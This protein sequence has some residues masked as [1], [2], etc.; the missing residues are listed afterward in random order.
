MPRNFTLFILLLFPFA[1]SAQS[2]KVFGKIINTKLEP[3]AF[4]SVE[5]KEV[6]TGATSHEDGTYQLELDEGKYDLVFSIIGYKP[7]LV[8]VIIGAHDFE[9]NIILEDDN[10]QGL[11]EVVIK[12]KDRADEIIRNVIRNKDNIMAASG[13]YS[14]KIYIKAVQQDS[15]LKKQGKPSKNRDAHDTANADLKRMAM[16]EIALT[17]D[18]ESPQHT[19]KQRTGVTKGKKADGLFYLS[20]TEGDFNFYKNL[21]KVPAVADVP[22]LSPISYSGLLAYKF[23]T[24][25]IRTE[26]GKKIFIISVKPRQLSNATVE[27]KVTIADSSW[28]I[29]NTQFSFPAYHLPEYDVFEVAQDYGFVNNRAWMIVRQQFTYMSKTGRSKVSG[30]TTVSYRDY[31]LNKSFE[32]KYFGQEVSATVQ[33]AYERDSAFWQ[34]T[35]TEPLTQKEFRF[36]RYK[37][38][39]YTATHTKSYLDSM[40]KVIN[41][42]T[43]KNVLFRG[44]IFND[45]EKERRW[46]I[47]PLISFYQPIQFGGSRISLSFMY[48]KGYASKQNISLWTNI[49]YGIRNHDVNGSIRFARLYNPIKRS[50]YTVVIERQFQFIFQGDAWINLLKRSNVYLNNNIGLGHSFEIVNGLYLFSDANIALRRSVSD[51]K[52]NSDID[53]LFGD[54]LDNNQAIY[55]KPY[56]ALYGQVRLQ[57]T[58]HQR[59]IREPKEKIILGSKWPT[60]YISWRKG[61]RGMLGSEV[62]FDYL[63]TGMEQEIKLGL[64]GVS[65]YSIKTGTFVNRSDLRLVDYKFQR[66]GDPVLFLNPSE[67]FQSLDSTFPVFNR[68]YE[69]HYVHDFNGAIISKIPLLR[70]LQLH[71]VAGAGFLIAPERNLRYGET[72]AGIE[73]VFKWPFNPLSKFKLGVY[74]VG[75]AANKFS[76]PVQFKIGVTTWDKVR[77]KWF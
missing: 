37:D 46:F 20:T 24:L 44:Q 47:P 71:E 43:L 74:V 3:L 65:R 49:S 56:N 62:N 60:F 19:K 13:A 28:V 57:Y 77:N 9:K 41:K 11:T 21:L 67:A 42:I 75:S 14:C 54:I 33:A 40:D 1:V 76:N 63:E 26:G 70:K 50:Y 55:F 59:Y 66:R 68:F 38:S 15:S 22:I 53:S 5:V 48:N 25:A 8:T 6:K 16:E 7:Q 61:I 2:H 52:T 69:A 64:A 45:H 18:Y 23:K 72:F 17:Y 35:R 39:I 27:G 31:E 12:G 4:V 10:S 32:K 34:T 30:H 29:L 36:V 58:P 51:Y 73:R